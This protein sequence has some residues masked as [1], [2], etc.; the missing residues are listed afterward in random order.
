MEQAKY[1]VTQPIIYVADCELCFLMHGTPSIAK[2][3]SSQ[4]QVHCLMFYGEASVQQVNHIA[5]VVLE[6][7][8]NQKPYI[9]DPM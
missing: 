8:V 6:Q 4:K 9:L 1:D 2:L 3:I 5:C 7:M